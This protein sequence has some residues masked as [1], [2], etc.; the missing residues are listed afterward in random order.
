MKHFSLTV[1]LLCLS[2]AVSLKA[3]DRFGG[4]LSVTLTYRS[5]YNSNLLNYSVRDRDRFLDG[6]E[7]HPSPIRSLDDIRS[8][9]KISASYVAKFLSDRKTQLTATGNFANHIMNPVKNFGWTSLTVSQELTKS[10]SGSF[11]YFYD[12]NYYIRDYKDVHTGQR[13]PCEFDMDQ[14]TVKIGYRP[15]KPLEFVGIGRFKKYAYNKYFTE[16]DSDYI[17]GGGEVIYRNSPWRLAAGYSLTDNDNIGFVGLDTQ[18][19]GVDIEDSEEGNG[20]YQQDSYWITVRYAFRMMGKNARVLLETE[21]N[22]RYYTTDRD[23]DKDTIHRSRRD[24][25]LGVDF[26]GKININHYMTI[27]VG[28]EYGNR[29]SDSLNP[30]VAQVKNYD[31][32]MGYIELSYELF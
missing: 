24:V 10:L 16:Y 20:D 8:D 28:S 11:N 9:F 18:L 5:T 32:T 17:E 2:G 23:L 6:T 21:L 22:D 14:W 30:I 4:E 19:S 3:G 26:S 7:T 29:C 27:T 15:V 31:R 25:V 1:L 13:H 12:I